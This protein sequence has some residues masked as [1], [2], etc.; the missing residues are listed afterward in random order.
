MYNYLESFIA[1]TVLLYIKLAYK[2]FS[3]LNLAYLIYLG[4]MHPYSLKRRVPVS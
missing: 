1:Y 3:L 4:Y 2:N